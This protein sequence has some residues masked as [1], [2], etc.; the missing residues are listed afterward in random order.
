M[1]PETESDFNALADQL[2]TSPWV[3]DECL[4]LARMESEQLWQTS[5]STAE[6]DEVTRE[7]WI[8]KRALEIWGGQGADSDHYAQRIYERICNGTTLDSDEIDA[9]LWHGVP[10]GQI[11]NYD[12]DVDCNGGYDKSL[13]LIAMVF[14]EDALLPN[15]STPSMEIT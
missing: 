13:E 10:V 9:C 5:A 7:S 6:D 14:G 3:M 12:N 4:K 15:D 8:V 11:A 1:A 2:Q